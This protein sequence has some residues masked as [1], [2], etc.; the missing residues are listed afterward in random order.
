MDKIKRG[1]DTSQAVTS[2][3]MERVRTEWTDN[4]ISGHKKGKI[5]MEKIVME[6][7]FSECRKN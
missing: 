3:A 6:I 4:L 1:S 2:S 5:L 7:R